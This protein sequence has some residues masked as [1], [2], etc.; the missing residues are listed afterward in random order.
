MI[1]LRG[2][3]LRGQAPGIGLRRRLLGKRLEGVKHSS[4]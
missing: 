2:R 4:A 3:L 1:T